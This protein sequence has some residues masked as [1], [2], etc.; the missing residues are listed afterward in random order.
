[1]SSQN[2]SGSIVLDKC[3]PRA[4]ATADA[5]R[6][7]GTL[8]ASRV[9]ELLRSHRDAARREAEETQ[10]CFYC[11]LSVNGARRTVDHVFPR[12]SFRDQTRSQGWYDLN[13]VPC[14]AACNNYKGQLLPLDW[15]VI[16]PHEA[17]AARLAKR[18]GMLG[19]DQAS[20]T[21]AMARRA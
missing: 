4:K 19:V 7:D 5:A 3:S 13:T 12:A 18:L 10:R 11:P 21:A 17:G 14:C 8:M 20:I 6:L 16:M 2:P 15:L 1:M 9:G